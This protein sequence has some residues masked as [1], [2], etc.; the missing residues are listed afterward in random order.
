MRRLYLIAGLPGTGKTTMARMLE[1]GHASD[2]V[3]HVEADHY[4]EDEEGTYR[5]DPTMLKDAHK[6]CQEM[7]RLAMLNETPVVIVSNTF[8]KRWEAEPYEAMARTYGYE[9][10]DII[11][12]NAHYSDE[13]LAARNVHK[14]PQK[15]IAQMRANWEL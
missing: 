12:D 1:N 2:N 15:K 3:V 14:V 4:F 13:E 5:F 10:V 9:V 11:M 6:W 8:V 7:V